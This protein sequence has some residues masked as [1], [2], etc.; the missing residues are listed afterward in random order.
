MVDRAMEIAAWWM[1]PADALDRPIRALMSSVYTWPAAIRHLYVALWPVAFFVR[2]LTV[3]LLMIAALSLGLGGLI[4]TNA[5][6]AWHG[7]QNPWQS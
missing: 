3:I 1:T 5:S 6:C 4:A 7:I 2:W